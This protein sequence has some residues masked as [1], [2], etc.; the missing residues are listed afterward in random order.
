[1][2]LTLT[3]GFEGR[4]FRVVHA[5]SPAE[6]AGIAPGDEAVALDG[7]PRAVFQ[8]VERLAALGVAA[9]QL[10]RLAAS[11]NQ[12]LGTHFDFLTLGE[13]LSTLAVRLG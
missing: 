7:P 4:R 8:Q 6:K 13:A 2:T 10:S 11:L 12:R 9:P 1:M 5:D 3:L